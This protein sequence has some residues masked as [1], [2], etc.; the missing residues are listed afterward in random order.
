MTNML[1]QAR[2]LLGIEPYHDKEPLRVFTLPETLKADPPFDL[3]QSIATVARINVAMITSEVEPTKSEQ[4]AETMK[5]TLSSLETE[6]AS[7]LSSL[8]Q[9]TQQFEQTK[10]DLE[11]KIADNRLTAKAC[12][13]FINTITPQAKAKSKATGETQ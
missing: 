11:R 2:N 3:E 4:Y 5:E 6:H 7:L 9:A 1:A 13:N 10:A 12:E 8:E